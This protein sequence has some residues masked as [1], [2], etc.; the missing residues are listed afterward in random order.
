MGMARIVCKDYCKSVQNFLAPLD[1]F[2][3]Q[4]IKEP[5]KIASC[6]TGCAF[7]FLV[8]Q[9]Q[10]FRDFLFKSHKAQKPLSL[11]LG[12][13]CSSV[14]F[15]CKEQQV[16]VVSAACL[17]IYK[18][19]RLCPFFLSATYKGE[20]LLMIENETLQDCLGH[21]EVWADLKSAFN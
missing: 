7:E 19:R 2:L 6:S 1:R 9:H 20:I 10:L 3:Q 17:R 11:I 13:S 5:E 4:N 15:L 14:N 18:Y 8:S 12:L 21:N 16:V